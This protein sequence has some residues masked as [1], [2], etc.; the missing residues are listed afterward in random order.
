MLYSFDQYSG[1]ELASI[2]TNDQVA[3]EELMDRIRQGDEP[4]LATLFQRHHAL[5]RTIAGPI[6]NSDDDVDDV[7]QESLHEIWRHAANYRV[8]KG[9]ALGWI[10]TLVRRRSI[11]R[12]RRR[13]SYGRARERLRK[14]MTVQAEETQPGADEEAAQN[15]HAQAVKQ[16]IAQL[17]EAQQQAVHLAFYRGMSQRQIA[18]HTGIPLGTIKT[19]L[20]LALRKLRA[21]VVAFRDLHETVYPARVAGVGPAQAS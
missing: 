9:L 7:L 20:E 19:R 11:D 4:A 2:S 15:D 8:E 14:E 6:L 1:K 12:V 10:V 13:A 21:A 5:L 16:L 18:A 3:D 17:P